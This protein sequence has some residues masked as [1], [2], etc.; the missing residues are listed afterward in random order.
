MKYFSSCC[1]HHITKETIQACV[2]KQRNA[3]NTLEHRFVCVLSKE[4]SRAAIPACASR[5]GYDKLH[6][7]E[8]ADDGCCNVGGCS[9][10]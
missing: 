6:D 8:T 4:R 7:Y 9:G 1:R 3:C 2:D 10:R 5:D